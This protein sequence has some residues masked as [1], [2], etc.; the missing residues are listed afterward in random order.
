MLKR[1]A[2]RPRN[3]ICLAVILLAALLPTLAAKRAAKSNHQV[4]REDPD[5]AASRRGNAEH[6]K[7]A[8]VD[9]RRHTANSRVRIEPNLPPRL[10]LPPNVPYA[11]PE[12]IPPLR[13]K[14]GVR[15]L[16]LPV[17][18]TVQ[19]P[20]RNA[21]SAATPA[22]PPTKRVGAFGA[23]SYNP[24]VEPRSTVGLLTPHVASCAQP[25][26]TGTMSGTALTRRR[27]PTA[28]VGGRLPSLAE[29]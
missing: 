5:R 4:R 18:R 9:A 17:R 16:Q 15:P 11:G 8:S 29:L 2:P 14:A 20:V 28:Q 7:N 19:V 27:T 12:K 23:T 22:M 6:E 10:N 1:P 24:K 26:R 25:V 21:V 3:V 13:P